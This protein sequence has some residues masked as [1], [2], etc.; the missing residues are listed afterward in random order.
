MQI[1]LG[2]GTSLELGNGRKSDLE[3][4][5]RKFEETIGSS[6]AVTGSLLKIRDRQGRKTSLMPN[7]AQKQ[8]ADTAWE[9]QRNIVL[10]ARQMGITTWIAGQFFLRTIL[11]P[12]TVTVQVA[13]TQEAAEQIFRIVHRFF[14]Q[15]PPAL[16]EGALQSAQLSARRLLIPELDSEYLVETAGDRNAGRGLTISNLHCTELARWPGDAEETLCGLLATLSPSGSLVMESTPMGASGC[17]W[18]QWR[19]AEKTDTV[20]H[21]FPWWLEPA[22]TGEAVPEESLTEEERKLMEQHPALT[23]EKIAYRRRIREN[24][25]GMAKQEYAE[26]ADTCFLASGSCYFETSTID[27]R[28]AEVSEPLQSRRRGGVQVW[29]PPQPGKKYLVAVDPAGGGTAGDYTAMQVIDLESGMQCAEARDYLGPGETALEAVKLGHEYNHALLAVERNSLGLTAL[30]CLVRCEVPYTNLYVHDDGIEGFLTTSGNRDL[31]LSELYAA[32]EQEP[33]NFLSERL[34]RECRCF[35]RTEKGRLEAKA[36]EH[37]DLVLAMAIALRARKN[38][39]D[40]GKKRRQP[41]GS[42]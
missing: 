29:L 39:L 34:L 28:L 37:D 17:F 33:G 40:P 10:K 41:C 1:D 32:L 11:H 36:G 2:N 24:F 7:E 18:N 4:V 38:A 15:L 22:Y 23:P 42:M 31:I 19:D 27:K 20:R 25:R 26:D 8:Y 3:R 12:G 14:F 9:R 21:F 16:R 35:I 13:H 6:L 5:G 30:S